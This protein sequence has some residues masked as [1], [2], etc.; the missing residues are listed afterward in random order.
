MR[1][2]EKKRGYRFV[3]QAG[4]SN[5]QFEAAWRY[6]IEWKEK[7]ERNNCSWK[8]QTS[9]GYSSVLKRHAY[10][11]VIESTPENLIFRRVVSSRRVFGIVKESEVAQKGMG[12][13]ED[14]KCPCPECKNAYKWG[15]ANGK[16]TMYT[17]YEFGETKG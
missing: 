3:I 9:G 4:L 5:E 10:G 12:P 17:L 16:P 13:H 8:D 2:T 6:A 11:K 7:V 15:W 14:I 1:D